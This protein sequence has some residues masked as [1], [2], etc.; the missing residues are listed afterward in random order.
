[1]QGTN[2]RPSTRRRGEVHGEPKKAPP[3]PVGDPATGWPCRGGWQQQHKSSGL[4][5]PP[6]RH[7]EPSARQSG[8]RKGAAVKAGAR[9]AW[10]VPGIRPASPPASRS[11]VSDPAV[12]IETLD[13]DP[14][15]TDSHLPL[16]VRVRV[17]SR[18][19][20]QPLSGSCAGVACHRAAA[21]GAAV[22]VKPDAERMR[23]GS[24]GRSLPPAARSR[25]AVPASGSIAIGPAESTGAGPLARSRGWPAPEAGRP[26]RPFPPRA[27]GRRRSSRCRAAGTRVWPGLPLEP[28]RGEDVPVEPVP[29]ARYVGSSHRLPAAACI[30]RAD[31]LTVSPMIVN[32]HR[33]SPP[34]VPQ[35]G[36]T[37]GAPG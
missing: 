3:L 16:V 2:Q 27:G 17:G 7:G 36:H 15:R 35:D 12:H 14:S 26:G 28:D 11:A 25:A 18:L 9:P 31:R 30:S 8:I 23:R 22:A 33:A 10:D 6:P 4:V 24:A 34:T 29:A 37:T 32:S 21:D 20:S 1:M 19:P 5:R 13:L